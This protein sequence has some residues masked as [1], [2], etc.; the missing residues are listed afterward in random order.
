MPLTPSQITQLGK[1]VLSLKERLLKTTHQ[2]PVDAW[3]E[4]NGDI[5]ILVRSGPALKTLK[6]AIKKQEKRN[7]FQIWLCSE[8][9][10]IKLDILYLIDG[11]TFLD[12][13]QLTDPLSPSLANSNISTPPPVSPAALRRSPHRS[14]SG[15]TSKTSQ[16]P[17]ERATTFTI[18]EKLFILWRVSQK[19]EDKKYD[20]LGVTSLRFYQFNFMPKTISC[21]KKILETVQSITNGVVSNLNLPIPRTL[22]QVV[23]INKAYDDLLTLFQS[24]VDNPTPRRTDETVQEYQ[25]I[26]NLLKGESA[27]ASSNSNASP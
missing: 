1:L 2:G 9:E 11:K 5:K 23:K 22:E 26:L 20:T 12:K 27:L 18:Q 8:L 13:S 21:A 10:K 3:L 4:G 25:K 7:Q 19:L 16:S 15:S 14:S 24:S 6:T 17:E